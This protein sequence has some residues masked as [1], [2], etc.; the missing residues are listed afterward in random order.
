MS[1]VISTLV[2]VEVDTSYHT[3]CMGCSSSLFHDGIIW[4][5]GDAVVGRY[6]HASSHSEHSPNLTGRER[7]DLCGG[8]EGTIG[9][10]LL[11]PLVGGS[12]RHV[13]KRFCF[14]GVK[15]D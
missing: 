4:S 1:S 8:S 5:D 9:Y 6:C 14:G 13:H 15:D 12:W 11:V 7:C 2:D 3:R 10:R